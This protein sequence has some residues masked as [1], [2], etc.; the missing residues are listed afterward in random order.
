[1]TRHELTVFVRIA[2]YALA[3][4][5]LNGGLMP[6]M[7]ANEVTNPATVEAVTALV[8]AGVALGWYWISKARRALREAL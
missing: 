4:Y 3:G 2:L 7:L 5:A 6:P 1:M 8:I